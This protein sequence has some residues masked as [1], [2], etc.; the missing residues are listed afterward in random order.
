ML[1]IVQRLSAILMISLRAEHSA[2]NAVICEERRDVLLSHYQIQKE[3]IEL[4]EHTTS[5]ARAM[6]GCS[7]A[8]IALISDHGTPLLA[9]P[10]GLVTGNYT[11]F[12]SATR[13]A[14]VCWLR[15]SSV[16]CRTLSL[17][18]FVG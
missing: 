11:T 13:A 16:A 3:L 8:N 14:P 17:V 9:D 6:F 10:G 2:T 1:H 15:L 7:A 12:V 18:G 5:H 4:N